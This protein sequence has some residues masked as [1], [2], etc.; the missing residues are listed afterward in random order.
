MKNSLLS[1]E[2]FQ[3]MLLSVVNHYQVIW[4]TDYWEH[5]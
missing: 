1:E 2:E 5:K 4:M 3:G